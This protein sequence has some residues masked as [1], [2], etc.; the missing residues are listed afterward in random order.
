MNLSVIIPCYR[1]VEALPPLVERLSGALS[2]LVASGRLDAFEVLLIVD[3]S[4]DSTAHVARELTADL[5][6]FTV[7]EMRRNFGQHNALVAGVRAAQYEVVVTMDD[8][9]QHPP[10]QIE[11]LIAPLENDH[12]DLAYGVPTVE[13]HGFL[14][15]LASRTV[16]NALRLAGVPNAQYV[17]AFRAFR[18]DLRDGF[19]EVKDPQV[20]LDVLLSWTTTAV[21]PVELTMDRRTTGT[22]SYNLVALIRH[23][24]NMVTGYGVVPLKLATWLGF[25]CG[26][27]GVVLMVIVVFRF[28]I[29]ETTVAG[30]TTV[31]ALVSLFAGAQLISLGIIGEYLGRA[32]FRSMH[33]PMYLLRREA[34]DVERRD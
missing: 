6:A 32:H 16:K 7:L 17:G 18:T 10:E 33:R 30:F 34:A 22:S 27:F 2:G 11:R 20:N 15:S 4:P 21:V 26:I 8:D 24:L 28:A 9:L 3:G 31:A 29:G 5:E 19:S 23:T 13:E 1:S 14:R 12:V 25:I